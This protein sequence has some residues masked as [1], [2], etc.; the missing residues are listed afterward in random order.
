[1]CSACGILTFVKYWS[2]HGVIGIRFWKQLVF[3]TPHWGNVTQPSAVVQTMR[4]PMRRAET[5]FDYDLVLPE[6]ATRSAPADCDLQNST[7]K[8]GMTSSLVG[9]MS[10]LPGVEEVPSHRSIHD[11]LAAHRAMCRTG[12]TLPVSFWSDHAHDLPQLHAIPRKVMSTIL[13]S[14]ATERQFSLSKRLQ[15]LHR[16]HMSD[17]LFE[18]LVLLPANVSITTQV[19]DMKK[20]RL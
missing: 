19:Y 16:C 8:R 13:S 3:F 4:A 14:A 15:G 17:D 10:F 7:P 12:K 5:H 6:T 11:E 1:M 20:E 18:E 2:K 9:M